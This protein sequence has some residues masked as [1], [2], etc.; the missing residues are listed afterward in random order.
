MA[1]A[2][3]GSIV[4][5]VTAGDA[6]SEVLKQGAQRMLAEVAEWIDA[7][8][9]GTDERGRRQVVRNGYSRSQ[10]LTMSPGLIH[11]TRRLTR[12]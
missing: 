11:S 6:L 10:L 2:T 12:R 7:R 8:A 1:E 3:T 4:F 9:D 5:P